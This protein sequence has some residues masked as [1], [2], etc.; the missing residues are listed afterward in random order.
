MPILRQDM[1]QLIGIVAVAALMAPA[2]FGS[3]S[4]PGGTVEVSQL[5]GPSG[6][7]VRFPGGWVDVPAGA[8]ARQQTLHV[9]SAPPLP[10]APASMLMHTLMTGITVDLSGLQPRLPLSIALPVP[11]ALPS[12]V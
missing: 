2:C 4:Q 3:N 5:V 1:P 11:S 10:S 12:G 8:V 6:M 7:K 9:R